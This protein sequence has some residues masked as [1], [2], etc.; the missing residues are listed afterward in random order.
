MNVNCPHCDAE[1]EIDPAYSKTYM[2]DCLSCGQQFKVQ[3]GEDPQPEPPPAPSK[4]DTPE[5]WVCLKCEVVG[6][7]KKRGGGGKI[8]LFGW[9]VITPASAGLSVFSIEYIT[10]IPFIG[11]YLTWAL[12]WL[13]IAGL[14]YG[15]VGSLIH[16]LIVG[17]TKVVTYCP[18]C[19]Y[20]EI[21]PLRS[22]K[23]EEIARKHGWL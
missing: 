5:G 6:K 16:G 7:P 9:F 3:I 21:I 8:L 14:A 1:I 10:R 23:G 11:G 19:G 15:L 13:C 17:F 22:P 12:S 20:D 2:H 4:P 18:N